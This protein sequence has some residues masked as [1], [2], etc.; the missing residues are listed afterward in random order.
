MNLKASEI[1]TAVLQLVLH[2]TFKN[3]FLYE[4]V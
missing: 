2:A 4:S 3:G 1:Q